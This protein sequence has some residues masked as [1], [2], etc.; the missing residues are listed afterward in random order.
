MVQAVL[1]SI[2]TSPDLASPTAL[3]GL[4]WSLR[5]IDPAQI[6]FTSVPVEPWP[7]NPDRVVW[8]A[9]AAAIWARVAADEPPPGSPTPSPTPS[10]TESPAA[11]G[12]PTTAE[13]TEPASPAPSPTPAQPAPT[14]TLPGVCA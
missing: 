12:E 6:V 3:A 5:E 8:T 1:R 7:R 11:S 13:T 4:A 14:P 2:S 10:P 9:D